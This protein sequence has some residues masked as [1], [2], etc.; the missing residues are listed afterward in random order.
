[1]TTWHPHALRNHN[2]HHS[3]RDVLGLLD[4]SRARASVV[5]AALSALIRRPRFLRGPSMEA[6]FDAPVV[7]T[8]RLVL[9]PHSLNDTDEWYELQSHPEVRRFLDWPTRT[10]PDS[11]GH[12]RDRTRHTRLWQTDDFLALGI[13]VD[14]TLIGDISLHLRTVAAPA[15]MVEMGWLLDP[16]HEG[17]GYATEAAI[18]LLQTVFQVLEV[19]LA[20]AVIST[21][22]H[23]SLQ[24]ATRLGFQESHRDRTTSLMTLTKSQ[25]LETLGQDHRLRE[26]LP[27]GNLPARMP[28]A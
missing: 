18:A 13:D 9:R 28:S 7:R 6:P 25:F 10:R 1:M 2:M 8:R 20:L 17:H 4:Q 21:D 16:R 26:M 22:N 5:P 23:K 3:F 11:R 27:T 19:K 12:L 15:R 24:L 14:G